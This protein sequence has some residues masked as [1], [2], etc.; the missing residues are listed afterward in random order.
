M[1]D[2]GNVVV[3]SAWSAV[4]GFLPVR[5]SMPPS[6]TGRAGW[7]R[8]RLSTSPLGVVFLRSRWATVKGSL[9]PEGGSA[10]WLPSRG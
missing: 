5:F 8:I 7:P 10:W 1:V 4:S 3:G 6:R 9:F 2:D